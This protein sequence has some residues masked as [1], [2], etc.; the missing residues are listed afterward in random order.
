MDAEEYGLIGS[1]E[2]VEVS[3]KIILFHIYYIIDYSQLNLC[4]VQFKEFRKKLTDNAVAYLNLDTPII[5]NYSYLAAAS[6]LLFDLVIDVTKSIKI[7]KNSARTVYDNWLQ[8][9]P[10]ANVTGPE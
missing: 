2:W 5:G 10:N 8:N 4:F 7:D 9:C 1:I 3:R 6:P